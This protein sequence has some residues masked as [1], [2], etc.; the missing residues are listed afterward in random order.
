MVAK[1]VYEVNIKATLPI[2]EEG[3]LAWMKKH[4]AE[5]EALPGFLPGSVIRPRLEDGFGLSCRYFLESKEA[6]KRY[7]DE[8]SPQMR[9]DLPEEFRAALEFDR[10]ELGEPI[11]L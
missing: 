2:D 8:F 3:F 10:K 7:Y 1:V 11:S 5:L 4:V 9:G 6:L